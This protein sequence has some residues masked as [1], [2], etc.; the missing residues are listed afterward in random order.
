MLF[1]WSSLDL[2]REELMG[3]DRR[4]REKEDYTKGQRKK[5]GKASKG[6]IY[7]EPNRIEGERIR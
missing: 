2:E 5:G 3:R 7:C 6:I 1:A 4:K